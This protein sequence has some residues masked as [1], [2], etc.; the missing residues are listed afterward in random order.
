MPFALRCCLLRLHL[1]AAQRAA[2]QRNTQS[3]FAS[4]CSTKLS[5]RQQR[6]LRKHLS[7]NSVQ[8]MLS[9]K[10]KMRAV[11]RQPAPPS[12]TASFPR[13]WILSLQM[14]LLRFRRQCSPQPQFR[15]WELPSRIM[16]P[17]L[18]SIKAAGRV[19]Q[20]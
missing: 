19:K 14:P 9:L 1:Q 16:Q 7:K 4:L 6:A 12:Q 11:I 13:V 17:R 18:I 5:M 15:S 8:T 3:V 20:A 2:A 10:S